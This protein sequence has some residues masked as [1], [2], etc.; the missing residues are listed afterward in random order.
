MFKSKKSRLL[1]GT[2]V[3]AAMAVALG[4]TMA[5][6]D[7]QDATTANQIRVGT[8]DPETVFEQS[9]AL[10]EIMALR[11]RLMAEAQRAQAEGDQARLMQ[12]QQEMQ[13]GQMRII[14]QFQADIEQAVPE[15]AREKGLKIV[16]V[17]ITYIAPEYGEPEDITQEVAEKINEDAEESPQR[18]G[19]DPFAP[20]PGQ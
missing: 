18:E 19:A 6:A 3:I 2:A 14:T 5:P 9:P 15:I 12:L 20:A 10:G 16:A 7:E 4:V 1:S 17:D 11:D 13:E 8:Y